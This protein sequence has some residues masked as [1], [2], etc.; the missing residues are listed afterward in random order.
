LKKVATFKNAQLTVYGVIGSMMSAQLNVVVEP[1]QWLESRPKKQCLEAK[2]VKERP[3]PSKH[4]TNN[5][6]QLI[7]LGMIGSLENAPSHALEE[8]ESTQELSLP[9][10][11][12]VVSATLRVI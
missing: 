8:P 12:M 4:A 11:C 3:M 7:V 5:L 1:S 9:K 2:N 6:A 10:Q